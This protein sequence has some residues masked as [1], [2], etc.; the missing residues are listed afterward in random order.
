MEGSKIDLLGLNTELFLFCCSEDASPAREDI[1]SPATVSNWGR[2]SH[3]TGG[4]IESL[5]PKL[6]NGSIAETPGGSYNYIFKRPP[7]FGKQG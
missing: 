2:I 4:W 6:E 5:Q 3:Q 7:W 1:R